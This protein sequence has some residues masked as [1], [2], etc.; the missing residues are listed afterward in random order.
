MPML[1]IQTAPY[2]QR[3]LKLKY[4]QN[5]TAIVRTAERDM[6]NNFISS[7]DQCY[8]ASWVFMAD[9]MDET[10]DQGVA[11]GNG[12]KFL[13]GIRTARCKFQALGV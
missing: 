8:S 6:I 2:T 7:A 12:A 5:R 1:R 10:E 13:G 3:D 9:F 11:V 4:R